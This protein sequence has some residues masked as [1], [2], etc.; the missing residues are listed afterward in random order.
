MSLKSDAATREFS[1]LFKARARATGVDALGI[2]VAEPAIIK[3][4]RHRTD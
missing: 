1:T 3:A 2:T 4:H